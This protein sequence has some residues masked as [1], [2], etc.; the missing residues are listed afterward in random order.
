MREKERE[1]ERQKAGEGA[2]ERRGEETVAAGSNREV[3]NGGGARCR[4]VVVVRRDT[5]VERRHEGHDREKKEGC[6]GAR[7]P[8]RAAARRA[9]R[10]GS[11]GRLLDRQ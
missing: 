2:S 6:Y 5:V 9:G 1:R 3:G 10:A 4:W 11:R 7:I 8:L